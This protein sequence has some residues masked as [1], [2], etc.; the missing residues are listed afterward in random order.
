[1]SEKI[2]IDAIHPVPRILGWFDVAGRV[3]FTPSDGGPSRRAFGAYL[4]AHEPDGP[5]SLGC[6]VEM[7][8]SDLGIELPAAVTELCAAVTAGLAGS[9]W[10]AV[11]TEGGVL[12]VAL[13]PWQELPA[14]G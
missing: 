14:Q 10:T 6:G 1:M 11:A 9:E 12:T 13:A 5:V 4:D 7:M 3:T 2:D 8:F